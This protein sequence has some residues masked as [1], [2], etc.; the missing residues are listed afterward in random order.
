MP[1]TT[2]DIFRQLVCD[3]HGVDA[4]K[5]TSD[6]HFIRDLDADSLDG[7]ELLMSVEEKFGIEISDEQ[8]E[9]VQTFGDAV[10]LIDRLVSQ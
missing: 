6:A 10:T 9:N 5:V 2:E 8:W 3:H 1:E 4:E 7:L